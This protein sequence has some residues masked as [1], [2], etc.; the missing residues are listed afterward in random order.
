MN[1]LYPVTTSFV[2]LVLTGH[3]LAGGPPPEF[4]SAHWIWRQAESPDG[5]VAHFRKV[6]ELPGAV[7]GARLSATCDNQMDVYINSKRVLRSGTWERPVAADVKGALRAGS[8]VIAVRARNQGSI[9]GLLL[10]LRVKVGDDER[11]IVTDDSWLVAGRPSRGWRGLDHDTSDWARAHVHG[12]YG[13]GPWGTLPK[14]GPA[15][16]LS[17]P[18]DAVESLPGFRV[19]LLYSVPKPEQGSWV[20]LTTDPRGRLI[21][22]DQNGALYRITPPAIGGAA[23]DT[24]VERLEVEIGSAQGL[25]CAFDSLYVVINGNSHGRGSGLYRVRDTDGDD[26]YDEIT[27]LKPLR[28]GG[29]HGPHAV[30]LAPDGESLLVLGGN[31]TDVPDGLAS[32]AVPTN[33]GEDLLLPRQ[34]D[35]RG[36]ARGRLAPG[37]WVCRVDPE[38]KEWEL[39]SVGYRNQ[40]DV[41]VTPEGDV[42]TYDADMEWDMGAPWYRPTRVCHVTSGS[43]FGWR[44][45]TGKWPTYYPDSLPALIDIGP[46]SPTGVGV[47]TGAKFPAKYQRAVYAL[48]WTF[49]TMYAIHLEP[50]GASYTATKEEFVSGRPLP[51]TDVVIGRDGAM[52]FTVGGR[53]TQSGLYRVTYVGSESTEPASPLADRAAARAR[54]TRR[55]LEAFHG[56][57]DPAAID[58]AWPHL[59]SADRFIRYAARIAIEHQDVALWKERALSERDPRTAIT[60]LIAL[61]RQGDEELAERVVGALERI[62]FGALDRTRKL[63]ILRAYALAFIRLG[64]PDRED[65]ARI[66]RQLDAHYPAGDDMLNRELSRVLVYLDSPTVVA[67]TLELM[68]RAEPE[69]VPDIQALLERNRGYGN[70]VMAMFQN[71]PVRQQIHYALVLRNVRFGWTLEQRKQYFSWFHEAA[72]AKGGASYHGFLNNI[73]KEALANCSDAERRELASI[74]G[75]QIKV[76]DQ[77]KELPKPKGPGRQWTVDDL[78][79]LV[80]GGLR[81]RNFENGERSYLAA[82]CGTC[83]RFDGAGGSVGPDLTGVVSRFSWPDLLE[84]TIEPSKVISDQYGSTIVTRRDG[85]ITIGR[86]VEENDDEIALVVDPMDLDNLTVVPKKEILRTAPA[87][88]SLMPE[89]LLDPL[90]RDE[91]LDLLA[92]MMSRGD[93]KD[94]VFR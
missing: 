76:A 18:A 27:Q 89:G 34:W 55:S 81:R 83:H 20:S 10:E 12:K 29:E 42:F 41:A 21:A 44:S 51:L 80:E 32:S 33:W 26:Q 7:A 43:E 17:T 85:S 5:E 22:S 56:R 57:R 63:E 2:V 31:H 47:G 28:G 23:G 70:T 46:G 67:K 13:V 77:P 66:A 62:D 50:A 93:P 64:K 15:V 8:N 72:K 35:A 68:A 60:A 3:L 48:D 84:A 59:G 53:G 16:Q 87:P 39:I 79:P 38:G 49:G 71:R 92:Y 6:F 36:H 45:G 94:R 75:E 1:R 82:R 24:R 86:I 19:E 74:T 25:L 30:V 73:R 14:G 58:A 37:G 78:L 54:E 91:V 9:A 4:S 88:I 69:G 90:N 40:Y 61:A 11:V 52:Y 65:A